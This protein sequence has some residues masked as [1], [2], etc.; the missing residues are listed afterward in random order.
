MSYYVSV[1]W[2]VGVNTP[3]VSRTFLLYQ[4]HTTNFS[5]TQN[6]AVSRT[7]F[8]TEWYIN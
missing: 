7:C 5:N 3:Q 4:V 6:I 2:N 1:A 8:R